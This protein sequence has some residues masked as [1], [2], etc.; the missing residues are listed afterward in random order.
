MLAESSDVR[1]QPTSPLEGGL[2]PSRERAVML[3]ETSDVRLKPTSPLQGGLE[4]SRER[5][6]ML[7][8]SSDSVCGFVPF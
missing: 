6:V 3:A 4:P 1:L 8:E 5:A 7:A 2:E